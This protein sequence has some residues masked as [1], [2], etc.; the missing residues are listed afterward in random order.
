MS[1]KTLSN[2]LAKANWNVKVFDIQDYYKEKFGT[3]IIN[4]IERGLKNKNKTI[5]DLPMEI[6][7]FYES[8]K[9]KHNKFVNEV[10][11]VFVVAE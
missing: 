3:Y 4:T 1:P 11:L 8:Y 5:E 10:K 6:R 2:I 9:N 7:M